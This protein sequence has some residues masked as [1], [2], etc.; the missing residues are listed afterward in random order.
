MNNL[1]ICSSSGVNLQIFLWASATDT[2]QSKTILWDWFSNLYSNRQLV[3]AYE[4]PCPNSVYRINAW[5]EDKARYFDETSSSMDIVSLVARIL[6]CSKPLLSFQWCLLTK[7]M[8]PCSVC[9]MT[10]WSASYT[11]GRIRLSVS[12]PILLNHMPYRYFPSC[13]ATGSP[14]GYM[15]QL[16]AKALNTYSHLWIDLE[17]LLLLECSAKIFQSGKYSSKSQ[18]ETRI[19]AISQHEPLCVCFLLQPRWNL[20][21]ASF[22]Q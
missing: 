14:L 20:L 10:V 17:L 6:I 8:K 18:D 4:Y 3:E 9:K 1:K 7:T 2:S 13:G 12:I 19:T 11:K 22:H 16:N 21:Y 15:Y 5:N